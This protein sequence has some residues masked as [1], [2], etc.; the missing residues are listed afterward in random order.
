MIIKKKLIQINNKIAHKYNRRS[1]LES[2]S[3]IP[4]KE[5]GLREVSPLN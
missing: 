3:R 1:F 2:E 5:K 4:L